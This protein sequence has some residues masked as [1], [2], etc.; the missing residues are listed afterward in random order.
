MPSD[1]TNRQLMAKARGFNLSIEKMNEKQSLS[2]VSG[3]Y[4]DDYN[5]LRQLT[6]D[7]FPDLAP[8]LPP[9]VTTYTSRSSGNKYTEQSYGEIDTYCEQ[10]F[11]LLSEME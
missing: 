6:I 9:S 8:L 5:R 4:G 3:D 2:T 10:I 7:N 1:I 11:Q